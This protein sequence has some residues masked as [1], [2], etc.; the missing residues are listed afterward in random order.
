MARHG[1]HVYNL[2]FSIK[3]AQTKDGFQVAAVKSF[4]QA[5][6]RVSITE[7]AEVAA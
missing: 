2:I 3:Y 4:F 1:R 6:A 7:K 5:A